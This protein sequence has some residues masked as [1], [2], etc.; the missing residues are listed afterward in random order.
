MYFGFL[1]SGSGGGAAF[2]FEPFGVEAAEVVASES[3]LFIVS[4]LYN[5]FYAFPDASSLIDF[6]RKR[7]AY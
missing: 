5:I 3:L 1:I 4:S 6:S 2:C 7:S